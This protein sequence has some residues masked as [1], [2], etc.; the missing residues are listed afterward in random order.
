M[1]GKGNTCY[2]TYGNMT[3]KLAPNRRAAQGVVNVTLPR[4]YQIY[5]GHYLSDDSANSFILKDTSEFDNRLYDEENDLTLKTYIPLPKLTPKQY[6][7]FY[8]LAC[9]VDIIE[10][11]LTI[12]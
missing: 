5:G 8:I 6:R 4:H 7:E 1:N 12:S 3:R 10:K 11:K 9:V 2:F